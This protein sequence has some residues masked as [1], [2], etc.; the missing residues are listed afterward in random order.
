VSESRSRRYE[1]DPTYAPGG[2][3]ALV[4]AARLVTACV[5]SLATR[6]RA[7]AEVFGSPAREGD[8]PKD[9]EAAR[10]LVDE[11]Y[12]WQMEL[13]DKEDGARWD[14][15][16][17][18]LFKG[19]RTILVQ[20]VEIMPEHRLTPR[21]FQCVRRC[22]VDGG[23]HTNLYFDTRE[24]RTAVV[25]ADVAGARV[26]TARSL[27]PGQREQLSK[28]PPLPDPPSEAERLESFSAACDAFEAALTHRIAEATEFGQVIDIGRDTLIRHLR[29]M[30]RYVRMLTKGDS[31]AASYRRA[32]VAGSTRQVAELL[33]QEKA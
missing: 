17:L 7:K 1:A 10:R 32:F 13:L 12:E 14:Q 18:V 2:V 20:S 26:R 24:R 22:F 30:V 29:L 31:A 9:P 16:S 8:V 23:L 19:E 11:L 33:D 5:A 15:T 25:I 3:E 27:T 21:E 28:E 4:S 6:Y